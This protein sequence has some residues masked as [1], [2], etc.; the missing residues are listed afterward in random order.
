MLASHGHIVLTAGGADEALARLEREPD[1]DLVLTD[2][3]MPGRTG[4]D[5]A[6]AVKARRPDV[7][8]GLIS[9]WGDTSDVDEARRATVDFVVEKP[10]SVEA[11]QAAVP[12]VSGRW[13]P[14]SI[15]GRRPK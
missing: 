9:G 1:L 13:A 6:A 4:W 2:L 3:V 15:G 7:A 5:V 12:R 11:P 14:A 8:V 10:V